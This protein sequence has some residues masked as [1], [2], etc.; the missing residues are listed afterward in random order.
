MVHHFECVRSGPAPALL[1]MHVIAVYVSILVQPGSAVKAAAV[2][3]E[4]IAFPLADRVTQPSL[5]GILREGAAVHPDFSDVSLSLK[6]HNQPAGRIKELN[7]VG[8]KEEARKAIWIAFHD[9][10]V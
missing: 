3:H 5:V 7:G 4:G 8:I 10:V 6:K 9:G 2:D 1:K